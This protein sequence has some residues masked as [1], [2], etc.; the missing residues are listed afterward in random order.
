MAI[1]PAGIHGQR[2]RRGA[3]DS[4]RSHGGRGSVAEMVVER[5]RRSRYQYGAR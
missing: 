4:G 1:S 3:G 5:V 2:V